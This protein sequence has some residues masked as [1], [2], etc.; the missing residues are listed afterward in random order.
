MTED[1]LA[2]FHEAA[3]AVVAVCGKWTKLAGPV[4][5]H[6]RGGGDVVMSTDG[7]AAARALRADPGFSRDVPRLHLIRALLAGPVAER[8]LRD[9]GQAELSDE[10]FTRASEL[11]YA[12]VS[13]QI[14][15]LAS[16]PPDLL[17]RLEAEVRQRL[18]QP[19]VW[20]AV[21]RFAAILL[22]RGRLEVDEASAILNRMRLESGIEPFPD[23]GTSQPS[24]V[25]LLLVVAAVLLAAFWLAR[26]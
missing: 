16:S 2:A 23:D 25:S 24:L 8:I 20:S 15:R 14:G 21:E 7:K 4:I 5:L 18:E 1:E 11:D 26:A 3:H 19:A 10:A 22:D 17:D 6:G 9:R 12:N 13:E